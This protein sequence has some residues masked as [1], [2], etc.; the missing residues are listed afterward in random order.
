MRRQIPSVPSPGSRSMRYL[1]FH[2]YTH[3]PQHGRPEAHRRYPAILV[4][5][6]SG[7]GAPQEGPHCGTIATKAT[8]FHDHYAPPSARP[9]ARFLKRAA[10]H[11]EGET[12]I[13]TAYWRD[14]C[15]LRRHPVPGRVVRAV[16]GA[17]RAVEKRLLAPAREKISTKTVAILPAR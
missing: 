6:R 3:P 4:T 12:T 10:R 15:H 8:D 9:I 5:G 13:G 1:P 2:G 17:R 16:Q 11:P 7:A 14:V